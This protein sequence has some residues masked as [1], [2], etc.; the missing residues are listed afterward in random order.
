MVVPRASSHITG[1]YT[2]LHIRTV[3]KC[4]DGSG[5]FQFGITE[6]YFFSRQFHEFWDQLLIE[7]SSNSMKKWGKNSK[8]KIYFISYSTRF[9]EKSY[10]PISRREFFQYYTYGGNTTVRYVL[11]LLLLE[12]DR[13]PY[14]HVKYGYNLTWVNFPHFI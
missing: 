4:S 8:Q 12:R 14:P 3:C 13:L 11:Y 5:F 9:R 6:I 1:T 2:H 7:K 10:W